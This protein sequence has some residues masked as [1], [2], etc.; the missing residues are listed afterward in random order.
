VVADRTAMQDMWQAHTDSEFVHPDVD[1][2]MAT[3]TENPTVLHVPTAMGGRGGKG[4]KD[5]YE[6]WF[7][8]RNPQDF[9]LRSVSRTVGDECIVDEMVVA[10]THDIDVPWI[11]PGVAPTGRLVSIPPR[12]HRGVS[13]ARD[14]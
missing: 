5:F 3:M 12:R 2:T 7:L 4:V 13:R 8:G 14:R 1:A 9:T 10:F 11:L 6:H